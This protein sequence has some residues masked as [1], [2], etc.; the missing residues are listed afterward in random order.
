MSCLQSFS[1]LLRECETSMGGVV[2]AYIIDYASRGAVT[3]TDDVIS[4]IS[5]LSDSGSGSVT[6]LLWKEIQLRRGG[7]SMVSTLNADPANGVNYISTE[8]VLSFPKMTSGKRVE[9][10]K[11]AKGEM[12]LI[13]K[14]ANGIFWLLGHEHPVMAS[15]GTGQTGTAIGDA[16][17]YQLTLQDNASTFPME[18][19]STVIEKLLTGTL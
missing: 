5:I 15:G 9:I 14:D 4:D 18:V 12:A 7:S 3:V 16:N 13:V 19:Q 8:V 2:E 10:A 1:G 17:N 6:P 11:M